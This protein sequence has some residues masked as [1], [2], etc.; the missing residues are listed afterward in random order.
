MARRRRFYARDS[1]GRFARTAGSRG[2]Y[3][4]KMSTR[5]KVVLAGAGAVAVGAAAYG[6]RELYRAGARKGW[7]IGKHQGRHEA[8]PARIRRGGKFTKETVNR[9]FSQNP[10]A[11]GYMPAGKHGRAAQKPKLTAASVGRMYRRYER[12]AEGQG[13]KRASRNLASQ[14]AKRQANRAVRAAT[15]RAR[16]YNAAQSASQASSAMRSGAS[17]ARRTAGNL[18]TNTRINAAVISHQMGARASSASSS[19]RNS[20]VGRAARS[21]A[22]GVKVDA[23]IIGHQARTARTR[24]RYAKAK[25]KARTRR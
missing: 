2:R 6:G 8:T 14:T 18:R 12:A 17:N 5:K 20:S 24:R 15:S 11:R 23:T 21:R 9:D 10:F 4:K 13:P 25:K 22:A 3:K 7:D 1:R 19:A 16:R